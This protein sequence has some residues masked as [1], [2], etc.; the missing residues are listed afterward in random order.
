MPNRLLFLLSLIGSIFCL[1]WWQSAQ[2][3]PL[4]WAL[5]VSSGMISIGIQHKATL[6]VCCA[7][8]IALLRVT[9]ITH[10]PSPQTVDW[11][12]NTTKVAIEGRII[13]D[14]DRRPTQT[15]YTIDASKL[16]FMDSE[17]SIKTQGRVLV[18]DYALWTIHS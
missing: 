9:S 6:T 4:L 1:Q 10:T 16:F 8:G 14:P 12:A 13:H 17:K 18:T 7:I 5:L 3:P 11:H 2:Y 15:K